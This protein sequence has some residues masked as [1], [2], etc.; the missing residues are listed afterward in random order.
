MKGPP[1]PRVHTYQAVSEC[2]H[3]APIGE[4]CL[5]MAGCVRS[6]LEPRGRCEVCMCRFCTH[7]SVI[8]MSLT[9]IGSHSLI[10]SAQRGIVLFCEA[11]RSVLYLRR[12]RSGY[13]RSR[14]PGLFFCR[15][16]PEE[17]T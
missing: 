11:N 17:S 14:H 9:A 8:S 7:T 5:P 12:P 16:P 1:A 2:K 3:G 4:P 10:A 13:P 15:T 6:L